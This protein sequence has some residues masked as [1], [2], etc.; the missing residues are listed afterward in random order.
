MLFLDIPTYLELALDLKIE[1]TSLQSWFYFEYNHF[2]GE[3]WYSTSDVI[4][5]EVNRLTHSFNYSSDSSF[6]EYQKKFRELSIQIANVQSKCP[7]GFA[8]NPSNILK[9]FPIIAF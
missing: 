8:E 3:M 6:L 4:E 7:P 2:Y 5:S 9:D 1:Y